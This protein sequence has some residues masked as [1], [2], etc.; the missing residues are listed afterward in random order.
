MLQRLTGLNA[1]AR[2][3]AA[4]DTKAPLER[5]SSRGGGRCP[6]QSILTTGGLFRPKGS[7]ASSG[8]VTVFRSASPAA[9]ANSPARVL[10]VR[11]RVMP[12]KRGRMHWAHLGRGL[13]VGTKA[14][15]LQT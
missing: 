5:L 1:Q 6:G 9:L 14:A 2:C 13:L 11:E 10:E 4:Y 15:V 8:A 12:V 3:G 7:R